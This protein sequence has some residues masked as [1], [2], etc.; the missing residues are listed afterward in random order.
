MSGSGGDCPRAIGNKA[1]RCRLNI[2]RVLIS[3]FRNASVRDQRRLTT[4]ALVYD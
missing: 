4:S 2:C 1:M 3:W